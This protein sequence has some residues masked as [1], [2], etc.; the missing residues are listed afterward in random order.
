VQAVVAEVYG[1]GTCRSIGWG[2]NQIWEIQ[3]AAGCDYLKRY[4]TGR[5]GYLREVWAL[6]SLQGRVPVPKV[7]LA[8]EE[9]GAGCPILLTRGVSGVPLDKVEAGRVPLVARMGTALAGLHNVADELGPLPPFIRP[10]PG[11]CL[12]DAAPLLDAEVAGAIDLE[13]VRA[14]MTSLAQPRRPVLAHRDFGDYQCLV[15]EGEIAAIVDWEA[16]SVSDPEADL[17]FAGAF[18]RAFRVPDEESAFLGAYQ[19]ACRNRPDPV[20]YEDLIQGFLLALYALWR[21]RG[22]AFEAERAKRALLANAGG[23]NGGW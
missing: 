11:P 2:N 14:A 21:G 22:Q 20:L 17:A 15:A 12:D 4:L 13:R 1:A 8:R 6:E 10:R 9:D 19:E 7:R 16:A 3:Y 18:L 23:A 5:D